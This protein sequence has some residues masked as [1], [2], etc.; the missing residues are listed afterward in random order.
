MIIRRTVYG[1]L[2]LGMIVFHIF[3]S[4]AAAWYLLI[5]TILLPLISL[6]FTLPSK[7]KTDIAFD[8]PESVNIGDEAH[9]SVT[10]KGN[11]FLPIGCLSFSFE[12]INK[13]TG[14]GNSKKKLKIYGCQ[15]SSITFPV[16]TDECGRIKCELTKLK[17]LDYLG[18]FNHTYRKKQVLFIN[19]FPI[20]AP[21]SPIPELPL[22]DLMGITSK[23]KPGGGF[24]EDY[25]IRGYRPGDPINLIHWK[26]TSKRDDIMIREPLIT[27]RGKA[28]LTFNLYGDS[29]VLAQT[30]GCLAWC[31]L[32]LLRYSIQPHIKW[33]DNL[34]GCERTVQVASHIEL[35]SLLI[36][37]FSSRVPPTGKSVSGVKYDGFAWQYHIT[38]MSFEDTHP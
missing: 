21:P 2:L 36:Q 16:R 3:Y 29:A 30:F 32:W 20:P 12:L 15:N 10:V 37:L 6:A 28:L 34:N 4:G 38:V 27:E 24:A 26:L 9:A 35:L 1:L 22:G 33:Y 23:P 19:V 5:L 17:T 14:R 13:M 25:D 18:L 7:R 31:V 8:I 11:S